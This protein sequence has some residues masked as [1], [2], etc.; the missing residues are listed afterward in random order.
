MLTVKPIVKLHNYVKRRSF[1]IL[2]GIIGMGT[3]GGA[4]HAHRSLLR[5]RDSWKAVSIRYDEYFELC[6][7]GRM[8]GAGKLDELL[9]A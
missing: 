3:I 7:Y 1:R 9:L 8:L 6:E 2:V 5:K 4:V